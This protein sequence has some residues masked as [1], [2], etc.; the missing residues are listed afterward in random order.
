MK[1]GP[2]KELMKKRFKKMQKYLG[3]GANL[4]TY[5]NTEK[6]DFKMYDEDTI[7]K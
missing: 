7:V 5:Y 6:V 3:K 1:D 4:Y 2:G